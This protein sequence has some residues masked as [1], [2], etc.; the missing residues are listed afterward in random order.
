VPFCIIGNTV[1][2]YR[3]AHSRDRRDV[4]YTIVNQKTGVKKHYL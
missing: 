4:F 1:P 2:Y 3:D